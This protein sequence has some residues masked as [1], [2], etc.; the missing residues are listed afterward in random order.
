[1]GSDETR[2]QING[3]LES[4]SSEQ[5]REHQKKYGPNELQEEKKKSIGMIF[6]EQYKDFLVII[7]IISANRLRFFSGDAESAAVIHSRHHNQCNSG[8]V[9]NGP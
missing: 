8:T 6:L 3:S 2:M 7:L 5:V 4:L 9:C 1:M